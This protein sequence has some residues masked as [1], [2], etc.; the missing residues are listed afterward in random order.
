MHVGLFTRFWV[1]RRYW[2][3]RRVEKKESAMEWF[4]RIGAA[5]VARSPHLSANGTLRIETARF[6]TLFQNKKFDVFR[7]VL[8]PFVDAILESEAGYPVR[9]GR[10]GVEDVPQEK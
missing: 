3:V 4:V 9:S 7:D 1:S 6:S 8:V 2:V 10:D 5:M